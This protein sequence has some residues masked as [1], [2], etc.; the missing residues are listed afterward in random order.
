MKPFSSVEPKPGG[1][2]RYIN[3]NLSFTNANL[4]FRHMDKISIASS[5]S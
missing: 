5:G 1:G 2:G 3:F 4:G